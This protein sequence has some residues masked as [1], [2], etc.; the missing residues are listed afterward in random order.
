[1]LAGFVDRALLLYG[2]ERSPLPV[3]ALRLLGRE[4]P[5]V[6]AFLQHKT[7]IDKTAFTPQD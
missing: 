3:A 7:R 4:R 2:G 1:V 6:D 5:A